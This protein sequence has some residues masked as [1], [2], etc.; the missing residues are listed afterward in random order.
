M[1]DCISTCEIVK[2]VQRLRSTQVEEGKL[3][4]AVDGGTAIRFIP[5]RTGE[6][7]SVM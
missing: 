5:R 4:L 1:L 6:D 3:S 2:T 7:Q